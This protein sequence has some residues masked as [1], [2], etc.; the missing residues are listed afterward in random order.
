MTAAELYIELLKKVLLNQI[1]FEHEKSLQFTGDAQARREARRQGRDVPEFALTMV[2]RIRLDN[3]HA[4]IAQ[5]LAEGVQGDFMEAGVWRGGAAI[6]MRGILEAY[7]IRDRCVWLADS[8]EGLP[9]PDVL[10]Y[11]ADAD[12]TLYLQT[13]LAVPLA[14]VKKNFA[15]FDLLDDQ[16]KF[17]RGSFSETLSAAPVSALAVLRLDGDLYESTYVALRHLYDKVVTGGF[18]IVDDYNCYASCRQ[19]VTDFAN[20]KGICLTP[21]E[22]DWTGVWWRKR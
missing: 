11:P 6:L 2:G 3:L 16:V 19:A 8:F 14:E 20:E 21:A 17:I 5:A 10:Q 18:I 22:I 12:N 7:S 1:Y 13:E 15:C 9:P 4:C